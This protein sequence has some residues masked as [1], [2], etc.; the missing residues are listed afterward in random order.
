MSQVSYSDLYD[1]RHERGYEESIVAGDLVRTGENL[2][3][4]FTVIAVHGDMAWVKNTQN[5]ADGLTP[6]DRCRK[7]NGQPAFEN[8]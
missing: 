8:A 3:P 1:I 2:F 5:G 4:N 6:V 7:I